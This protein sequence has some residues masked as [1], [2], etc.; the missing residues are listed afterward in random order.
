MGCMPPLLDAPVEASEVPLTE[1]MA[2][3]SAGHSPTAIHVIGLS[4]DGH[5]AGCNHHQSHGAHRSKHGIGMGPNHLT[6]RELLV[7][8]I[9]H[10]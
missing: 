6:G 10:G 8:V 4:G 9:T 1:S 5:E 3:R 7:A 2:A